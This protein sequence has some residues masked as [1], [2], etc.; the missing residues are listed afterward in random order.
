MVFDFAPQIQ[1]GAELLTRRGDDERLHDER[2]SVK[3]RRELDAEYHAAKAA[4]EGL[5]RD[6]K[7]SWR[8]GGDD[9]E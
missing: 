9:T 6:P 3:R 4:A 8:A 1:S 5:P 2:A 7:Q